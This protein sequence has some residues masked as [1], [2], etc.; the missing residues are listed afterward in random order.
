MIFRY[1][2]KASVWSGILL[3]T[4]CQQQ[5]FAQGAA[6]EY[7]VKTAIV[8]KITKFVSWP[9]SAF[10]PTNAPLNI[11]VLTG[12]PFEEPMRSLQGR[13]VQGHAIEVVSYETPNDIGAQCQVLVVSSE[14]AERMASILDL[15]A[16][17][18]T[19]TIG[20]A[21]GF[22]EHGGIVGLEVQ[23]NR[24]G[25]AINVSASEKVGLG[26]SAQLLQLATI[27]EGGEV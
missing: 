17:Q 22:A 2:K 9:T 14:E 25:F 1:L 3:L 7:A 4:L 5:V 12:S 27:V 18:P 15:V 13:K 8:Y 16:R 20:D 6:S 24:V 21:D 26:I 11:C 23:K 19:L 10:G